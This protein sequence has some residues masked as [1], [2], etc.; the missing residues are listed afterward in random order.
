MKITLAFRQFMAE[1]Y[2]TFVILFSSVLA[3]VVLAS[4]EPFMA[5]LMS[6]VVYGMTY[7]AMHYTLG[8]ISGGHF[9]PMLT[10]AAYDDGRITSR[11]GMIY[12]AAQVAA[13]VVAGLMVVWIA[14]TLSIPFTVLGYGELSPLRTNL[15]VAL[16]IELFVSYFITYVYLA[17]SQRRLSYL[18]GISVGIMMMSVMMTTGL[19]T[20]GHANPARVVAT[21][22]FEGSVGRSQLVVFIIA[23]LV[24]S[25]LAR[26]FYKY[27]KYPD[28]QHVS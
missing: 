14:K 24:G 12:V 15:W 18:T 13:A 19:L 1:T 9:N 20:G 23:P 7:A 3:Y 5:L 16:V 10:V 11:E 6:S 26:W 27:F 21:L 25:L 8:H 2:G 4:V 28:N 17:V 22:L